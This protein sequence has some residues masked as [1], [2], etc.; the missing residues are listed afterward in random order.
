[1]PDQQNREYNPIITGF[2]ADA[3]PLHISL[4]EARRRFGQLPSQYGF[5]SAKKSGDKRRREKLALNLKTG[6]MIKDLLTEK[7]K[8]LKRAVYQFFQNWHRDLAH[9][10][11]I[12]INP[13][14]NMNDAGIV[15]TLLKDN[16]DDLAYY[17]GLDIRGFLAETGLIRKDILNSIRAHDLPGKARKIL[18]KKLRHG[19]G[20]QAQA[21]RDT[22]NRLSCQGVV[23]GLQQYLG[24]DMSVAEP[25]ATACYSDEIAR[26]L[27]AFHRFHALAGVDGLSVPAG[28]GVEF[29]F[30]TRDHTYLELGKET[31]DCTADKR[32]F[33]ADS[34]VENIFWTVFS[35]I[36]DRNYQI[37]KV[38]FNG[39]F[40]MKVHLMPLYVAG[41]GPRGEFQVVTSQ[42]SGY[43]VLAVDA[44]ETTVA[45]RGKGTGRQELMN[46]KNEIFRATMEKV[47][48]LADAMHIHDIYAEKFSN[49]EWVRD[50]LAGFPEI[51]FHVDHL[52]KID[53]LED[54]YSLAD[55]ISRQLGYESPGEIFMELQMKNTHLSPGYINKAPGVKSFAMI[56]GTAEDGIPMKHIIGV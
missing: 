46:R 45:F 22:L 48:Q 43:A 10:F 29:T 54:V 7:E 44:I 47:R 16:M 21:I 24:K 53:Q 25:D 32:T 19:S 38:F 40:V 52:V 17:A 35:W 3:G 50:A 4:A 30:T 11:H 18:E 33:Q 36:L 1:M 12:N 2:S 5:V 9:E 26:G 14:F 37:L 49:T 23:A 51:F 20:Q 42:R 27:A 15:R 13:F 41:G 31:G 8:N 55:R 28:K 6:Y 56:R 34:N 39:E